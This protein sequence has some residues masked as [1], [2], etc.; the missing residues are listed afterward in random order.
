MSLVLA[1]DCATNGCSVAAVADGRV[2]ASETARMARGQSEVLAPM[3]ERVIAAS[4]QDRSDI[5]AIAA[6]R[7][8]GAFTG[9]RIGLAA[10]RGLAMALGVPCL[11][12]TTFDALALAA[13]RRAEAQGKTLLIAIDTKRDDIYVQAFG[14]DGRPLADGRALPPAELPAYVAGTDGALVIAGDAAEAAQTALAALS[15]RPADVLAGIDVPD[16]GDVGLIASNLIAA[17][18]PASAAA[19]PPTPLYLRPPDVTPPKGR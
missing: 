17:G 18:L 11:G 6:T 9:L 5:S 12:V 14:A 15:G 10:A 2:M 1:L 19:H 3:I 7:G 4:G 16:A 8:P 13:R